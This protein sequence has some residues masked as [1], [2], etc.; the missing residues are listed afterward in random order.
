MQ[1]NLK[2]HL[3]A[4]ATIRNVSDT[5]LILSSYRDGT[6]MFEKAGATLPVQPGLSGL[7]TGPDGMHDFQ[8][9]VWF[10]GI[11]G[12]TSARTRLTKGSGIQCSRGNTY[13]LSRS[14]TLDSSSHKVALRMLQPAAEVPALHGFF[15]GL[16]WI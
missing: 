10:P 5:T 8:V 7:L 12:F 16:C 1:R 14:H 13:A 4:M 15:H 2:T 11:G 9:H 3:S 6:G